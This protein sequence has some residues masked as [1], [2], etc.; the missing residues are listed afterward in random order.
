MKINVG[1]DLGTTYSAV[2]TFNKSRGQVDILKNDLAKNCTPSVICI[3]NG[4]VSIGEE[5]KEE[6]GSGNM[7]TAAFY[8]SMMGEKDYT[9]YLDGREYTPEELSCE[10]LRVLKR[11][12]E[13]ENNVEIG[14]AVITVPAYFNEIQRTSTMRAGQ[15]AGLNVLKII[16]EPT[17]AIIAYGLTGAG[18]KNVMVYDLGGGTF[19]VTIAAV[20]GV[21]VTVLSTNGN[22]QLGGKDWDL[23]LLS[24]MVERFRD[25]HGLNIEDYPEEYKE[26]QVK[27]EDAKKKLTQLASTTV[28][29]QC[30]G[31]TGRYDVTRD[32]FDTQTANLLNE[33]IMLVNKCFEEIGGGFGWHSLDEVV[34]VG[35]STRMP[36]VKE[37]IT[38]EY[39]K[40][41]ITK[42]ID[43]DTI[44]AAG[45]AMQAQLSTENVLV[46]GGSAGAAPG[47]G[48]VGGAG[49][50]AGGLVIRGDDIQD[51]T[52][53]GLGMLAM[54]K[55]ES[56]FVNSVIIK[57]NSKMNETFGRQYQLRGDKLDVYVLQGEEL[58]PYDCDLLYKYEITGMP[59]GQKNTFTV[60]FLY[61]KNGVVDAN[62]V[63]DD[64]RQL[65]AKQCEITE[66]ISEVIARLT[67]ERE[68]AK[69]AVKNLEIMF[70]IDT[71]GSMSG[72]RIQQAKRAMRE[73]V[74]KLDF[75]HTKV[76]ILEFAN[77]SS[78]FC[79]FTNRLDTIRNAINS[80]D[81]T[82]KHGYGTGGT[83]LATNGRDFQDRDSIKIMVVLT[84]GEWGNQASE[85]QAA[86]RLKN[87]GVIIY[88][89][90][91][92]EADEAFLSRIASESGAKKIDLSKLSATFGELA[93]SIATEM[94]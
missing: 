7:N 30:E 37:R 9:L 11:I 94:S 81:V 50:A 54:A 35:G 5:A 91:V 8:K 12:I 93:T 27:C 16:N 60:N 56:G 45:A 1:I 66:S 68:E 74:D 28:T 89:I 38:Q 65:M 34:L 76:A 88:A 18:K 4:R 53:H 62:A 52:A 79:R 14:G 22:H 92:S 61:N 32:F 71:S 17:A 43:V 23:V 21:K 69:R 55:D 48:G 40:P 19:D 59:S 33:T 13:E 36:Q 10:Y 3:E 90:G 78:F 44:V 39:G 6:Q 47:R 46:L 15:R 31:Y 86:Q 26:L 2:A 75:N 72:E 77:A 83:P 73:F 80:L 64:G 63:L 84:D 20:D 49:G 70:V 29:V 42:N 25:E 87:D 51:I 82:G 58:S 57:K 85:I 67:K 24:E 41:P